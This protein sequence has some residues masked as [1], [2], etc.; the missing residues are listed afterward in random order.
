MKKFINKICLV[1][2]ALFMFN[3]CADSEPEALFEDVP[4][5]RVNKQIDELK[6]LLLAPEEGWKV[7][8]FTDNTQLG[9]FTYLINFIDEKN[10]EMDSDFGTSKG[11]RTAS[12]WDVVFGSTVKLSFTT[13]N[14]IHEL[15]D[16]NDSPDGNLLGQGYRGSFEF[17]YYGT[18]GNDIIFKANKG[19]NEVRFTKAVAEDW[20]NLAKNDDIRN[21]IAGQL[22][23]EIGDDIS[24]FSYNDGRRFAS[25]INDEVNDEDFGIGFTP[26]GIIV[27]PAIT[28]D[29]G[30]DYSEFTL[31]DAG[32]KFVSEDEE[33]SIIILASPVD[34]NQNWTINVIGAGEVSTLFFNT[35]VGVF[36]ANRA[37]WG[38]TLSTNIILG[39][40]FGSTPPGIL[41]R[42][43]SDPN[44]GAGF[45]A[46]Y[47]LSFAGLFS[48][49]DLLAITRSSGGFNWTFYGQLDPMVDLIVDNAP[50][51]VESDL[52]ID[53]TI[54]TLTSVS[55]PD[56]F[57]TMRR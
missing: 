33:F 50:Y 40:T 18:E 1:S 12:E 32:T 2:A 55:N 47:N 4:S 56:V 37:R 21:V 39:I 31:N 10:V 52:L 3:A 36:N 51:L 5:I 24:F 42:S 38:E 16:S 43:L 14:K 7:T 26:S 44:T 49:P 41:F 8:Y 15:S 23:Y 20:T 25:N 35:F 34:F 48:N 46:E 6:S 13:R 22:A 54:V 27:S 19:F 28:A 45:W 9:G 11:T 29:N 57:F 30:I 17:L 53:P